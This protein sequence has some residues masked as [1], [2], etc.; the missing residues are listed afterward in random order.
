M[1][2]VPFETYAQRIADGE[3]DTF[4][5]GVELSGNMDLTSLLMSSSTPENNGSNY[6]AMPMQIWTGLLVLHQVLPILTVTKQ[7]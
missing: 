7:L 3:Y 6:F 5:G 2:A 4:I 1:E